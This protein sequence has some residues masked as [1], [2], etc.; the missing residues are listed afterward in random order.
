MISIRPTK[1]EDISLLAE[2]WYDNLVLWQQTN[3][4]YQLL[5]NAQQRWQ[6]YLKACIDDNTIIVL[7]AV[8]NQEVFGC[9]IGRLIPNAI[10]IAPEILG[11][12]EYL[13]VDLHTPQHQSGAGSALWRALQR[14]FLEQGI[15]TVRV[16]IARHAVVQQA[17][18]RGH[19]AK[20]RDD[21]FWIAL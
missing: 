10:G 9:I 11:L 19:G 14:A 18:W 7:S 16:D 17:F 15:E 21:S 2:Y 6:M 12:V 3:P 1:H 13:V 4:M 20:K 8:F 5:P